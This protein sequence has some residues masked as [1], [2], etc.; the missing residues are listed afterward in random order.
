MISLDSTSFRF[1]AV[2]FGFA[3]C[4]W[5]GGCWTR[6]ANHVVVYSALDREFSQPLLEQFAAHSV[7]S[8]SQAPPF[9]PIAKYDV[10]STK[11]VGLANAILAERR[12]PRCDL[13]WNNEILHTIRLDQAGL[14]RPLPADVGLDFPAQMQNRA[15]TWCGFAARARILLVNTDRMPSPESWPRSV[16]DLSKRGEA[17]QACWAKPFFGTTATHMAVLFQRLG[18]ARSREF[19]RGTAEN[20]EIMSGNKQCAVAV[21]RGQFAWCLTDTDDAFAEIRNG[22]PVQMIFPDQGPGSWGTLLIPNTI[23]VMKNSPHPEG[24]NAL[25]RFLLSAETERQLAS[26]ASG[27]IPLHPAAASS[28]PE[29]IPADLQMMQVDFEEVAAVWED[30]MTALREATTP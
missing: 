18:P 1:L 2:V 10:E 16:L 7:A 11:T 9:E 23:C 25:S 3:L 13:F 30:A 12:R 4:G 29:A 8:N 15:R 21:G 5:G 17:G 22:R 14:L 24:A 28:R 20:A 26:S 6:N 19:F 27:Q